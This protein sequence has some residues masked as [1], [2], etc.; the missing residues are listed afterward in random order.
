MEYKTTIDIIAIDKI[1]KLETIAK[2]IYQYNWKNYLIKDKAN[3]IWSIASINDLSKYEI[4]QVEWDNIKIN[5]KKY[6]KKYFGIKT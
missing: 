5:W 6:K 3:I 2:D 4:I 1:L